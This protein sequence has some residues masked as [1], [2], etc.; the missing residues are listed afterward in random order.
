MRREFEKK[1]LMRFQHEYPQSLLYWIDY[2]IK[3][4]LSKMLSV[5]KYIR[6]KLSYLL[7]AILSMSSEDYVA[8]LRQKG[9]QIGDKTKFFDAASIIIDTTRPW[10]LK[11]GSY[12][13]ITHGVVILA[14]DYSRSVLRRSHNAILAEGK[15]TVIGDNVFIARENRQLQLAV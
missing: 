13:K 15:S 7:R 2:H 3:K 5:R 8:E 12:C 10:V 14:H 9:I 1:C 11:I 6:N 4:E